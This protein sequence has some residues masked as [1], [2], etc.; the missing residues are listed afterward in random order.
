MYAQP[1]NGGAPVQVAPS[2]YTYVWWLGGARILFRDHFNSDST[3]PWL[4]SDLEL[5]DLASPSPPTLVV[6]QIHSLRLVG[7][8]KKLLYTVTNDPAKDGLYLRPPE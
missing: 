2:A 4:S 3:A 8:E 1:V 6:P 7:K 5:V